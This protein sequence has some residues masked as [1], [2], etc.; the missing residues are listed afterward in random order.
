[1][2]DDQ[3]VLTVNAWNSDGEG[4]NFDCEI[5]RQLYDYFLHQEP[6]AV[7]LLVDAGARWKQ[8]LENVYLVSCQMCDDGY[9]H[10]YQHYEYELRPDDCY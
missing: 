5:N 8:E 9:G 1:M 10:Y 7:L 6:I 3:G 2:A 4:T